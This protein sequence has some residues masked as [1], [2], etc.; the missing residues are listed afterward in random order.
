M[1]SPD[2]K[3]YENNI[4]SSCQEHFTKGNSFR[5]LIWGCLI[6]LYLYYGNTGCG[7]SSPGIQIGKIFAKKSTYPKEMIEF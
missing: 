5:G 2:F 7:V 3:R 1:L 6:P 4:G